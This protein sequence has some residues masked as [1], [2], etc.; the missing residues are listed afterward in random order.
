[1]NPLLVY[2]LGYLAMLLGAYLTFRVFVRRAYAMHGRVT[3]FSLLL[4]CLI[5]GLYCNYP[6]LYLPFVWPDLP[7]LPLIPGLGLIGLGILV[8]VV[9]MTSLGFLRLTGLASPAI[10]RQ[11]VYRMSRNPQLVGFFL[12]ALGFAVLWPSWYALGWVL[13]F[14]PCFHMMVITEE[15][16]LLQMHGDAYRSYCGSVPRYIRYRRRPDHSGLKAGL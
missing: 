13:L 14:L 3:A 15:A 4:E 6:Y 7:I 1:M 12:Y 9:G 16:Y 5:C 2:L 8:I 10:Y 11:G